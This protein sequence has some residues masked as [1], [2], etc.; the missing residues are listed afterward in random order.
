MTLLS[1]DP[2][3]T[4]V[5]YCLLVDGIPT[6]AFTLHHV[7]PETVWEMVL[8]QRPGVLG[9]GLPDEVLV[10]KPD[11]WTRSGKNVQAILQVSAVAHVLWAYFE[12]FRYQGKA[13]HAYLR[14]VREIRGTRTKAVTDFETTHVYPGIA[15]NAHE[16]DALYNGLWWYQRRKV[17]IAVHSRSLERGT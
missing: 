6:N 2:G 11:S 17:E 10:E 8:C 15:K 16:R 7:T 9:E 5:G 12:S 14:S 13:I 4:A 1:I 3:L